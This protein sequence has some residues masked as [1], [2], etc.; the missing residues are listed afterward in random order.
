MHQ[1][2]QFLPS[3][4][5]L[6]A[7]QKTYAVWPVWK[8]STRLE[9]RFQP[10][11]K[12]AVVKLWHLARDFERQTRQPNRQDGALGRNG[13]AVLQALIFDFLNFR[14]GRLDPSR[15]GIARAACISVRSVARG[16]AKLRQAG[17]LHWLHRC[18]EDHDELGRFRLRQDTK[19]G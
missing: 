1:L 4:P 5:G 7:G 16:L 10:L 11:S 12:K 9:V 13:L 17:V 2:A 3:L 6:A 14:T 19:R 18:H 8:D 15:A